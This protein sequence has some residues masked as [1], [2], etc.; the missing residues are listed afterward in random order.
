[1]GGLN[2]H[3]I[4]M[5]HIRRVQSNG[6]T[7]TNPGEICCIRSTGITGS[8]APLSP[9]YHDTT[10]S[11]LAEAGIETGRVVGIEEEGRQGRL[12]SM[13]LNKTAPSSLR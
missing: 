3:R 7:E 10:T 2:E 12:M 5:A 1:M 9:V 4:I 8:F 11:G 6:T 13:S